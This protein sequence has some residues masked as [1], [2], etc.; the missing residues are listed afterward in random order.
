MI[1]YLRNK[2][3]KY[4]ANIYNV[5]LP[6]FLFEAQLILIGLVA[7]V[8]IEAIIISKILKIDF[9]YSL[10]NTLIVNIVTTLFGFILQGILKLI[11]GMLITDGENSFMNILWGNVGYSDK[12]SNFTIIVIGD[13]IV[14]LIITCSLSIFIEYKH[15]KQIIKKGKPEKLIFKSVLVANLCSYF[16]I[17]V[18]LLINLKFFK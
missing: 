8:I 7:V 5:V 11:F 15:M 9:W 6:M 17:L 4:N 2:L 12:Y 3:R 18:Y 14:S 13:L 16:A 10:K 1:K